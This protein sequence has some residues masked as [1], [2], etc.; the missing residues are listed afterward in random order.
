MRIQW[1]HRQ[2]HFD[3]NLA[4]GTGLLRQI[5]GPHSTLPDEFLQGA[6]AQHLSY[7]CFR[8]HQNVKPL[9]PSI[10]KRR[11]PAEDICF[12]TPSLAHPCGTHLLQGVVWTGA[13]SL[14]TQHLAS[15]VW[16]GRALTWREE[17]KALTISHPFR[18]RP[19]AF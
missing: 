2:Q 3:G 1:D 12:L 11:F 18:S 8:V 10:L 13:S 7:Q 14:F 19:T 6:G 15:L 5:D 9:L 4:P 16:W 17:A